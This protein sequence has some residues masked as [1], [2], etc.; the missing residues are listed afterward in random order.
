M[1][2]PNDLATIVAATFAA[3][4]WFA[5]FDR[6]AR[7]VHLQRGTLG[8]VPDAL[9]GVGEHAGREPGARAGDA[10]AVRNLIGAAL[11]SGTVQDSELA[12]DDPQFGPRTLELH[13]R[14]LRI[15]GAIE[16]AVVRATD[17][18]HRR[19]QAR[20]L[21]LQARL[22][23][24]TSEATLVL[25]VRQV[26]Q[27]ANPAAEQLFGS[28]AGGLSGA[29]L[30]SLGERFSEA[31]ERAVAS[32]QPELETTIVLD[33]PKSAERLRR[34]LRC[35]ISAM[36]FDRAPHHLLLLTDVSDSHRLGDEVLEAERRERERIARDLHDGFGQDLTGVSLM[37]SALSSRTR[38]GQTIDS[39]QIQPIL[40][41][42]HDL[43]LTTRMVT[44]GIFSRPLAAT[45]LV[46]AL[47]QMAQRASERAAIDVVF[48]PPAAALP[49]LD[50][51]AAEHLYRI[52]QEATTNAL[53]HSGT[54]R[55]DIS[56]V[57]GKGDVQLVVQ[58]GGRGFATS[59]QALG[60]GLR[61]M[62]HRAHAAGGELHL[63]TAPQRGTRIEAR[64][65][66]AL[67]ADLH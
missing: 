18:T 55:I 43:V 11:Q 50:A 60:S 15:G 26:V 57:I 61:I 41:A 29:P 10:T 7:C 46:A 38:K 34:V 31:V 3:S 63:Q 40:D 42:V 27:F 67:E 35:R 13:V 2:G 8:S 14:P 5:M 23:E 37:L 6:D 36:S 59:Q 21:R 30:A 64:I 52:A 20:A 45:G 33:E 19:M 17:S 48:M 53:R 1:I 58:D 44:G 54:A 51:A 22:L 47:Q 12:F 66:F 25:D 65:P 49:R 32:A 28:G 9:L 24:C 4:D 16:G 56:L 39:T 62:Q